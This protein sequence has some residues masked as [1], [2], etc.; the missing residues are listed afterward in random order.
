MGADLHIHIR[1]PNITEQDLRCFFSHTIGHPLGTKLED[2]FL[3]T[4]DCQEEID[5]Q[6]AFSDYIDILHREF[7]ETAGKVLMRPEVSDAAI[8]R[9][10]ELL[11]EYYAKWGYNCSHRDRVG[12][13]PSIWVGEVSWLKAGLFED[14]DKYVPGPIMAVSKLIDEDN[15]GLATIDEEFLKKLEDAIAQ[16]NSTNYSI[17]NSKPILDFLRQYMGSQVFTISW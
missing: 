2:M 13:T 17:E 12:E 14:S 6:G 9:W 10:A 1:T 7:P 16:P 15:N 8:K 4:Y 11:K 5:R 3:K